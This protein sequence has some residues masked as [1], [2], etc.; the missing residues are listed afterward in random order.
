MDPSDMCSVQTKKTIHSS[1]DQENEY[2]KSHHQT[3]NQKPHLVL[4]PI[5][6]TGFGT[7]CVVASTAIKEN[8]EP[9]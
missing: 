3:P 2:N 7:T 6:T 9:K 1:I 8:T 5:E 4:S